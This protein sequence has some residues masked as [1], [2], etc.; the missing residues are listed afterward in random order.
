MILLDAE[1]ARVAWGATLHP[2]HLIAAWQMVGRHHGLLETTWTLKSGLVL[3]FSSLFSNCAPVSG[4]CAS[5]F[6]VTLLNDY[7]ITHSHS[8]SCPT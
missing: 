3:N 6:S 2:Q 8:D 5:V 4:V 1:R 7:M